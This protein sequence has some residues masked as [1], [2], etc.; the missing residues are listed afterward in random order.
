[1][2]KRSI[3]NILK[4]SGVKEE[5]MKL[6]NEKLK[7]KS[8]TIDDCDKLLVKMGYE[9]LFVF[10]DDGFDEDY[11]NYDDFEPIHHKKNLVD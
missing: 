8:F 9:K 10:D 7:D 1:M 3:L 6:F 4:S 5:H 2:E 11:E